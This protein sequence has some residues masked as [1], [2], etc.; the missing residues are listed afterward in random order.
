MIA[1]AGGTIAIWDTKAGDLLAHLRTN[2]PFTDWAYNPDGQTLAAASLDGT[3]TFY[4]TASFR[5]TARFAWNLG[6]LHSVAFAPDGLTC[7]AGAG[8]GQ[9]LIWDL[10]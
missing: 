8:H 3:I 1:L 6:P 5:E 7:A 2:A 10:G 4:D 9:V